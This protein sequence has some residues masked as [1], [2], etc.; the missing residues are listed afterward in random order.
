MKRGAHIDR[1]LTVFIFTL[2]IG[3]CMIFA[4]AALGYLARGNGNVSSVVF[5]HLVL[6][7][8]LGVVAL[9]I[10]SRIDYR[11]WRRWAPYLFVLALIVTA[12]VFLPQ[13][14]L[15]HGGGRRW[16][17]IA[18]LSFQP[19]ETLKIATAIMAAAYF[20]TIRS[21]TQSFFHT[22]GGLIA[23]LALPAAILIMQPDIG[24]LGI[25]TAIALA[26]FLVS[27]VP[28]KHIVLM[29]CIVIISLG[30]V[31]T[32]KPYVR[33][34][35][36]TFLY[37]A[38][39]QQAEGYQ[40][41]QS[42]IAIGSGGFSGRGF[43]Q[44]IQK[45]TY[46]PEP[47]GDSIFAVASEEL[48]FIGSASIILL[49]LALA[50]RGFAVATH[51]PDLFGTLLG[52]GISTYLVSEAFINIASML[53]VAPLTGIPL[54]FISQGGSAMLTSLASAGILLNISKYSK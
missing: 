4:S 15:L 54:T 8:G 7:A 16:I 21:Q 20:S 22:I 49:F 29:L 28:W 45:F 44:G 14:G 50:L 13:I 27:G 33:D 47:M 40:I 10:A 12:L 36:M 48:G 32:A 5:N 30:I 41:R 19:S 46:L 38:Q 6:G 11:V 35:V 25:I 18:G 3:G 26:I 43:G 2:L 39:N 34:R 52:V 51:A 42:L 23:I 17:Q 9:I 37:P 1:P 53:G 31:I 24:T